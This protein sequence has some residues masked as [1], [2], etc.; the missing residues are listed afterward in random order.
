MKIIDRNILLLSLLLASLVHAKEVDLF[1][2]TLKELHNI[3]VASYIESDAQ[4]QP[5]SIYIVNAE[6]L[7]LSGARLLTHALSLLVP[8]YFFVDDQDDMIAGF[9]GLASDNNAKVMVLL[10]G[11]NMNIDWFWGAN[12]ALINSI[13]FDWIEHVEIV[14]GPGS[15]TLGQGALLGVINIVTKGKSF[16]GQRI[17]SRL[18]QDKYHHASYEYGDQDESISHYFYLSKSEYAGQDM[19]NSAWLLHEHVG[20]DGGTI[21]DHNPQLNKA[22]STMLIGNISH[23]ESGI[24]TNLLYVDQTKDLYNF[25]F[26]RDRF[27]ERLIS[28]DIQYNNTLKNCELESSVFF[29][30]D[31][32]SLFT[33]T[34]TRTGGTR[35]D[36]SGVKMVVNFSDLFTTSNSLA[37]GFDYRHIKAGQENDNGDNYLVNTLD[38][39]TI[40]T[41]DQANDTRTWVEPSTTDQYG[42]FVEDFYYINSNYTLFSAVRYDDHPGWGNNLSSRL[43]LLIQPLPSWNVR[44]SY[45]N[46]FR[47]TVGLNYSGGHKRDGFLSE[48][49]FSLVEDANF[50]ATNPEKV[51]PENIDS[52]ELELNY[53]GISN[54]NLNFV[55]FYNE[56]SN[57]IDFGAFIP[58]NY[59]NHVAPLPNVGDVPAGDGWGGFW[60]YKNIEGKI[61]TAG[62]E[63]ELS[64][65]T[66]NLQLNI[67]HSYVTLLAASEEQVNSNQYVAS[68]NHL[69]AFPE[70]ISRLNALYQLSRKINLAFNYLYFYE[71]AS[72][73]NNN[74]DANQIL[75]IGIEFKPINNLVLATHLS[76]AL[77]QNELYP[78][79]SNP[80]GES[81]SDGTPSL[82]DRSIYFSL[83]YRF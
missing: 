59:P 54:V 50:G 7:R 25:W 77:N 62:Y 18:G 39:S 9:R 15:V 82:E 37:L 26:D 40:A 42:I 69:K 14:R 32:F 43:G 27:Q 48:G 38:A 72:S 70:N 83:D 63:A 6:Q 2:L 22:K 36:R 33:N 65:Q 57:V 64:Y 12:D 81:T 29:S 46:G 53:K 20:V 79:T 71:W 55:A 4:K 73:R 58:P 74:A 17:Y 47:G 66:L 8:G 30:R 16:S 24:S 34:G 61:Y 67:S 56:I 19:D 68:S 78:M 51:E 23:D 10:N 49:N 3:R 60:F 76:N 11:V 52:Y 5:S 80:G 21:A 75:N 28:I 44:L 45:Q 41:L 1:S 31:D 35:E 13:N